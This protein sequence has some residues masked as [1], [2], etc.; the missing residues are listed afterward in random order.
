MRMT[1]L[2]IILCVAFVVIALAAAILG[3][4]GS[5]Q[6]LGRLRRARPKGCS[7][8]GVPTPLSS[9]LVTGP[10]GAI[11]DACVRRFA[12]QFGDSIAFP[13]DEQGVCSFCGER[14]APARELSRP[15]QVAWICEICLS[16]SRDILD[17]RERRASDNSS[18]E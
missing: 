10:E 13:V 4:E 1:T 18:T 7:F 3:V 5:R 14:S 15:F 9:G 12:T 6:F 8:C 2:F 17:Q 16:V 11:C